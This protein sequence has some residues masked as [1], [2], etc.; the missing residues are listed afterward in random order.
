MATTAT[1]SPEV[2]DGSNENVV[3]KVAGEA[4]CVYVNVWPAWL[5]ATVASGEVIAAY[6][7]SPAFVAVIAHVPVPDRTRRE[8]VPAVGPATT[9]QA[10]DA[11]A[12]KVV[13]PVPEPPVVVR[14]WSGAPKVAAVGPET[15]S[16]AW[17]IRAV[18]DLVSGVAGL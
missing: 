13:A 14:S 9:E 12:S 3:P 15:E 7:A 17:G 8:N 18:R 5:I 10:V 11:P 2:A 4:G 1:G 16:G 6:V